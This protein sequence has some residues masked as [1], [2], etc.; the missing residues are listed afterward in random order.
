M[1]HIILSS[2][3]ACYHQTAKIVLSHNIADLGYQAYLAVK[4]ADQALEYSRKAFYNLPKS[5]GGSFFGG[6]VNAILIGSAIGVCRNRL[7][8]RAEK[9]ASIAGTLIGFAAS[10]YSAQAALPLYVG[11]SVGLVFLGR[12][13][14]TWDY[15]LSTAG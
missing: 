5:I 9:C 11:W 2:A 14:Y 3:R 6:V 8:M 13:L 4:A 12:D 10:A 7:P 1:A 15:M